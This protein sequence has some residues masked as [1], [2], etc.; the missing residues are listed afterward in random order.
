M[1]RV[2]DYEKWQFKKIRVFLNDGTSTVGELLSIDDIADNDV[3]DALVLDVDGNPNIGCP[4]YQ[5]DIK[6]IELAD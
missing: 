4:I 5:K 3:D 2:F 6:S 1:V